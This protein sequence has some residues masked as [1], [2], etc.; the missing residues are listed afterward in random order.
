MKTYNPVMCKTVIKLDVPDV[1]LERMM[2]RP[3]LIDG[4]V[5]RLIKDELQAVLFDLTD[6]D[7]LD[8]EITYRMG[9]EDKD[10]GYLTFEAILRYPLVLLD[11]M[12]I[13]EYALSMFREKGL[14]QG[15]KFYG[16]E[17]TNDLDMEY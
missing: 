16:A 7:G 10:H 12:D 4:K 11:K 2:G 1:E 5:C 6:E 8:L 14:P 15:L 13:E 17:T 3:G 9:N